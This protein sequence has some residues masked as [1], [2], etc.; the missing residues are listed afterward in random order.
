MLCLFKRC[1]SAARNTV[2]ATSGA[3]QSLEGRKKH[4]RQYCRLPP[5]EKPLDFAW[6]CSCVA[7]AWTASE[8]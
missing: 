7:A 8:I 6:G 5:F 1:C 3:N 2:P 4:A